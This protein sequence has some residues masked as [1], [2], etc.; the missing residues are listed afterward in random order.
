MDT[1]L[2]DQPKIVFWTSPLAN[3]ILIIFQSFT[4]DHRGLGQS[5]SELSQIDLFE[6]G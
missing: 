6:R 3:Q 5:R 2:D 4:E 1:I